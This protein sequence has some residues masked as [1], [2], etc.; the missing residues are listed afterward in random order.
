M[1]RDSGKQ[2]PLH[3]EEWLPER[4]GDCRDGRPIGPC[5]TATLDGAVMGFCEQDRMQREGRLRGIRTAAVARTLG[6][7]ANRSAGRSKDGAEG[8]LCSGGRFGIRRYRVV[9]DRDAGRPW[10]ILVNN[11]LCIVSVGRGHV[12]AS[13][14]PALASGA[15]L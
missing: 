1:G 14:A 13:P 8:T 12:G 5:R 6:A 9:R 4:L 2:N 11:T 7:V 10:E 3:P 15:R